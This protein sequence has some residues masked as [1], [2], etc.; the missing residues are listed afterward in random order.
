MIKI[1]KKKVK[2]TSAKT[3]K[4]STGLTPLFFLFLIL[5]LTGVIDWSWVW[6]CSP[7]WIPAAFVVSIVGI[8]FIIVIFI[9]IFVAIFDR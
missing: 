7:L 2:D 8:F 4:I 1:E 5:K 9:A 3:V 6:V